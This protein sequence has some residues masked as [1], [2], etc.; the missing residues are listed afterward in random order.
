MDF[1]ERLLVEK[2]AGKHDP[3]RWARD[4]QTAID[5]TDLA[6]LRLE[7]DTRI[8]KLQEELDRWKYAGSRGVIDDGSG[9]FIP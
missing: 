9:K 3:N 7:L 1:L 4:F 8:G 5:I 6:N 2:Y